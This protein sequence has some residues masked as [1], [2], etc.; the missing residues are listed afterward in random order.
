M[1]R[2]I[3]NVILSVIFKFIFLF[4]LISYLIYLSL[5]YAEKYNLFQFDTEIFRSKERIFIGI[6]ILLIVLLSYICYL[7]LDKRINADL[8]N[9][10][11]M[12]KN[13]SFEN[14][15][16][17]KEFI[18]IRNGFINKNKLLEEKDRLMKNSLNFISHDM[19]TPLTV[20]NTNTNLLISEFDK[21]DKAN[22][23]R[24]LKIKSQCTVI[25]D[26][27]TTLMEVVN[28]FS[29]SDDKDN[30]LVSK[31]INDLQKDIELYSDLLEE[32]IP[33]IIDF[34]Y[35]DETIINI[36]SR[37]LKKSLTHLLNNAYEHRKNIISVNLSFKD[38][39]LKI[40][41]RDDGSGFNE[42][43]L[44]NAKNIFYTDNIGRTTGKG[45]GIGLFYVSSFVESLN[46]KLILENHNEQGAIQTM[47][48]PNR[49][50]VCI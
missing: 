34:N 8:K 30:I 31:L 39:I 50:D 26:Y 42:K 2:T 41:V 16:N 45:Y 40:S 1:E 20:I 44:K 22:L 10:L 28:S 14:N 7:D 46:G 49:R 25:T 32:K 24:L 6:C 23:S 38:H 12:I 11:K 5:D 13:D 36:N 43:A 9:L 4:G 18:L 21:N 48:I 35:E 29:K 37:K 19:K 17:V 33:T 27:I 15:L 47:I 3:K